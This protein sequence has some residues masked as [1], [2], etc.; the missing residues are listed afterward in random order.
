M[1]LR[2]YQKQAVEAIEKGWKDGNRRQLLVMATGCGKTIIFAEVTRRAIEDGKRVL[3]LAHREELLTQAADKLKKASGLT[4]ALEKAEQ[5]AVNTD[6]SVIIASVQTLSRENRL[7]AYPKTAFDL[8]VVDEAHHSVATTY[9][10]ILTYFAS[11]LVLG[12]TATP[13]RA[14]RKSLSQI[15]DNLAFEYNFPQ[16]VHEGYLA[17]VRVQTVPLKM[18]IRKVK[19][20]AGDF[21]AK[22][23]GHAIEPYLAAIADKM[24]E[25]CHGRKTIVFLPLVSL[26]KDFSQMLSERGFQAAEID[27]QTENR[28]DILQR[29]HEG[30]YN[31]LCNAMILTEGFD[32]ASVDCIVILRPTKSFGL[33]T[34]M[35]GRG[36]RLYPG[37]KDLLLLDFLWLTSRYDLCHPAALLAPNDEVARH[38]TSLIQKKE[39]GMDLA[40]ALKQSLSSLLAENSQKDPESEYLIELSKKLDSSEISLYE[41]TFRWEKK[42]PTSKQL[43]FL[44]KYGQKY[45]IK[46]EYVRSC[47]F[48]SL[49]IDRIRVLRDKG[50]P[51]PKQQGLLTRYGM[52]MPETWTWKQ[53]N[54]FIQ[55][56]VLNRWKL[57]PNIRPKRFDPSDLT[58]GRYPGQND[59]PNHVFDQIFAP[60]VSRQEVSSFPKVLVI[61]TAKPYLDVLADT[62]ATLSRHRGTIPVYLSN[63]SGTI[64]SFFQPNYWIREDSSLLEDLRALFPRPARV[65][66]DAGAGWRRL[67]PY[68]IRSKRV[69]RSVKTEKN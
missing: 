35:V 66:Y 9:Q 56:L 22:D 47:G 48:A 55:L 37:K 27:N 16:A 43:F 2:P 10:D 44:K 34:Q 67:M 6:A 51:S 20:M 64:G 60:S 52:L 36:T 38:M 33:Y 11:S 62:L 18:D 45:G 40:D 50:E 69:F 41:P 24:V 15:Y 14:D 49:L 31:A 30:T 61:E 17:N 39:S 28:A 65:Y 3:I 23:L 25:Y 7:H 42:K 53:A 8:I 46:L 58:E 13:S 29:F 19:V 63:P 26:A 54:L 57:P 68:K 21:Q 5:T 1:E 32:E 4:S 59:P 12:V